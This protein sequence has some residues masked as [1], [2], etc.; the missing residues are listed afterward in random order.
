[1]SRAPA[2]SCSQERFRA[3]NGPGELQQQHEHA[4]ERDRERAPRQ[5][6]VADQLSGERLPSCSS[7]WTRSKHLRDHRSNSTSG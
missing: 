5:A 2:E 7:G 6:D 4:G 1:V 3:P